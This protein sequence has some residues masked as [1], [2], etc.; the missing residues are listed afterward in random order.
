MFGMTLIFQQK[1][2]LVQKSLRVNLAMFQRWLSLCVAILMKLFQ[3]I[4]DRN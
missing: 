4:T 2:A 1:R 3:Q